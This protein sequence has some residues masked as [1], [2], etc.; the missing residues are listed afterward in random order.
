MSTTPRARRLSVKDRVSGYVAPEA[1]VAKG[2]APL[3][4]LLARVAEGDPSLG[5][6]LD[7]SLHSGFVA[8]SGPQKLSALEQVALG[9]TQL[10]SITLNGLG[11]DNTH[12][13]A[14]ASL[15]KHDGP[16]QL[17]SLSLEANKL[18]EAAFVALAAA[19]AGHP[20]MAELSVG[21]QRDAVST[22]SIVKLLDAM[23]RTP[24]LT[25]LKLGQVRDDA[26][27]RRHQELTMTN[28]EH[29]RKARVSQTTAAVRR[30][31]FTAPK[32]LSAEMRSKTQ[33]IAGVVEK[34]LATQGAL[35]DWVEEAERIA[36]NE[37]PRYDARKL[38]TAP[39]GSCGDED[40][41]GAAQTTDAAA[42]AAAAG[43][44]NGVLPDDGASYVMTGSVHWQR[45]SEAKR[46][47]VVDAFR[48]NTALRRVQMSDCMIG[49]ALAAKWAAVLAS[50][51]SGLTSLNLESN[52]I[53]SEGVKALAAALRTN[54]TLVELK[55][56]HQH[57]VCSTEAEQALAEAL[58][59]NTTLMSVGIVLRSANARYLLEKHLRR[60]VDARRLHRRA[61]AG[62]I[63]L[64][65]AAVAAA[66]GG[67]AAVPTPVAPSARPIASAARAPASSA[68]APAPAPA[69]AAA[70]PVAAPTSAERN[71]EFEAARA[72]VAA[73]A[74]M[75]L[76]PGGG[77]PPARAAAGEASQQQQAPAASGALEHPALRRAKGR[78]QR[79]P[80]SPP[81]AKARKN[82]G[83]AAA[84]AAASAAAAPVASVRNGS[85]PRAAPIVASPAP[86]T[87]A[88]ATAAPAT[89]PSPAAAAPSAAANPPAAAAAAAA[90]AAA[91]PATVSPRGGGDFL[92]K[93]AVL[94]ALPAT[95]RG[96]NA[97][98]V[99]A[100]A[101]PA[102]AAPAAAPAIVPRATSAAALDAALATPAAAAA[103]VPAAAPATSRGAL[104]ALVALPAP[105]AAAPAAAAASASAA[106]AALAATG[107]APAL[108]PAPA[109]TERAASAGPK[110]KRLMK[111]LSAGLVKRTASF[112]RAVSPGRLRPQAQPLA[113]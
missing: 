100:A 81:K 23:E 29:A 60:N 54:T 3:A 93:L 97:P 95:P 73:L 79:R 52:S 85:T 7:L 83:G 28:M 37:P 103:A 8:L 89:A 31:S 34:V 39:R 9:A 80:R 2:Q 75:Q 88:P 87:A 53:G 40:D 27:R 42:A 91:A 110:P 111:Q 99:K 104:V 11:L 71:V 49:E 113:S 66:V 98:V 22:A 50:P 70:T 1:S 86:A 107:T 84:P 30:A 62:S 78:P 90:P 101:A 55:L 21:N 41:S 35:C 33:K 48:T 19:L 76:R 72:R 25:K 69:P 18:G 59:T 46:A 26:Q 94:E 6:A 64:D 24:T 63:S 65:D 20:T 61:T 109:V 43:G 15:L 112:G 57:V 4:P 77:A 14:L 68:P 106:A 82:W 32:M 16:S 108:A 12:A 92:A 58:E 17:R 105:A 45:A 96:T 74:P 67:A 56:V 10:E 5:A 102:S 47:G 38:E 44:A 13:E 51:S 36:S